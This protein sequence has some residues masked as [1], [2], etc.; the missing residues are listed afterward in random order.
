[1]VRLKVGTYVRPTVDH[2]FQFQCGTIEGKIILSP[3]LA[4]VNFNS[5]VVRLKGRVVVLV[6]GNEAN[7]NSSVVRLKAFQE[8]LVGRRHSNFNSSWVRLKE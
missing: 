3:G 7:F 1:M 6:D 5:S 8:S 2:I 4:C